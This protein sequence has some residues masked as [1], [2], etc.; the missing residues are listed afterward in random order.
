MTNRERMKRI[1]AE[2]FDEP[3]WYPALE[4][5]IERALDEAVAAEAEAC[6]NIADEEVNFC[7][8]VLEHPQAQP[9]SLRL[10]GFQCRKSA[11]IGIAE[12]I[13]LRNVK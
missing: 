3:D 8:S 13:R 11:A 2:S 5:N 9:N 6:A 1:I 10:H 4:V 7:T 12:T